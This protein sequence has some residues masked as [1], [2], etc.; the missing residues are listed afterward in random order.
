LLARAL[1]ERIAFVPGH[2]FHASTP[3]ARTLRLSYVTVPPD[4]LG[5]AVATLSRLIDDTAPPR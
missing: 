2:A 1:A 5:R 3:D 4:A